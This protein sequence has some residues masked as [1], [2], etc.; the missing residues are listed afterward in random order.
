MIQIYADGV[1]ISDSRLEEHDL[2]G[3]KI[4][5]GLNKGGTAEIA[6]PPNHP[7]YDR[8]A[9]FKTVVEIHRDGALRFRGRALYPADEYDNSRTV[10]CEGEMCFLLDGVSRPYL[11]ETNP[12]AI[13][14]S[15]IAE[16]NA[17][18]DAFKQFKLGAVTV[19]D[20]NDYI[21][22]ESEE[23]EPVLDTV[24]K[25]IE[26]CGGYIVFTTD[27]TGA[28]VINWLATFGGL[29]TQT[30]DGPSSPSLHLLPQWLL[31]GTVSACSYK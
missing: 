28:R 12:G 15:V 7:A 18:V 29:S 11:Y 25:L 9:G 2:K 3:L 6:M 13:F 23:A 5:A 24:N 16:Y 1:L 20:P 10:V 4:T 27:G 17:Q 31:P 19:T 30:I 22:F 26:R 14:A 8:F 21:R